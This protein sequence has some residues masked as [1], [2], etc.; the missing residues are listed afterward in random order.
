MQDVHYIQFIY[1]ET[2]KGGQ[3]KYLAPGEA[4]KAE[5]EVTER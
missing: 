4:P 1:L 5:F 2:E 3:V